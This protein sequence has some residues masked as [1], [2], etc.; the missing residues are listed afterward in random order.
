MKPSGA[1]ETV[2]AFCAYRQKM[3]SQVQSSMRAVYSQC[4]AGV[5]QYVQPQLSPD[6]GVY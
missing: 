1:A 2:P 6:G 5:Y 3:E 4:N